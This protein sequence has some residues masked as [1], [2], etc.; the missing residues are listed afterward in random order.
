MAVSG[1]SAD[2]GGIQKSYALGYAYG[3]TRFC[4]PRGGTAVTSV[5]EFS[6]KGWE[7]LHQKEAECRDKYEDVRRSCLLKGR[8]N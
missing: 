3:S 5:E 4:G 7:N 1:P 8:S 2:R 6:H